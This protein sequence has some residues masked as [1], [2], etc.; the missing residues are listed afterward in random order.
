MKKAL[1]DVCT[2]SIN[3]KSFSPSDASLNYYM[4]GILEY[5]MSDSTRVNFKTFMGMAAL[6]ERMFNPNYMSSW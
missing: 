4:H 1:K 2:F 3:T 6:A 5:D